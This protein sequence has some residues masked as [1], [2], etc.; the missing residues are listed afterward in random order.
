MNR[1]ATYLRATLVVQLAKKDL[2]LG[3]SEAR[4]AV[5]VG[6]MTADVEAIVQSFQY[7]CDFILMVPEIGLALYLLWRIIG[8]PFFLSLLQLTGELS[9]VA[10]YCIS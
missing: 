7:M 1:F 4:T 10:V 3:L 5:S 8:K 2:R 9:R 6:L